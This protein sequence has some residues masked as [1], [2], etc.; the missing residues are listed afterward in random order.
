MYVIFFKTQG[1]ITFLSHNIL[2]IVYTY[3]CI[4][5]THSEILQNTLLSKYD[6]ITSED[7][8]DFLENDSNPI[9]I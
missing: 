8:F 1:P 6:E 3:V 2:R 4:F 7:G 5:A 9:Q